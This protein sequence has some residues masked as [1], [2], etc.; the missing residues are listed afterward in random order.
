MPLQEIYSNAQVEDLFG[1]HIEQLLNDLCR[2]SRGQGTNEVPNVRGFIEEFAELER[3]FYQFKCFERLAGFPKRSSRA[4][5]KQQFEEILKHENSCTIVNKRQ[6]AKQIS[7]GS[8][9]LFDILSPKMEQDISSRLI[10]KDYVIR[11]DGDTKALEK[12]LYMGPQFMRAIVTG[13][14][15]RLCGAFTESTAFV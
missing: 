2:I 8:G 11:L 6:A 5:V 1:T 13:D 12:G 14:K 10:S 9:S 7:S 4:Q 3:R 15:L